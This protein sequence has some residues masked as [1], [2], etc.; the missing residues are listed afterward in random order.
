[1]FVCLIVVNIGFAGVVSW[2]VAS[3]AYVSL[4]TDLDALVP[5]AL[6]A[7]F[8]GF[9]FCITIV[10]FVYSVVGFVKLRSLSHATVF[11]IRTLLKLVFVAA[12]LMLA[13]ACSFAFAVLRIQTLSNVAPMWIF[14]I[15]GVT[16][17]LCI[18]LAW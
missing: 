8:V 16:L 2:A 6:F 12:G 10:L 13:F 17:P 1:V 18:V 14:M 9:G 11:Q 15:C 4:Y 3:D 7:S 5:S